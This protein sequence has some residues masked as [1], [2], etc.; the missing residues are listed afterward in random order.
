[1]AE[2]LEIA[3]RNEMDEQTSA[4]LDEL[5]TLL[6]DSE[7]LRSRQQ[8]VFC[9]AILLMLIVL[10]VFIAGMIDYF[11]SY[12]KEQVMREIIRQNRLFLG[13]PYHYGANRKNDQKLIRYFLAAMK[14]E[15]KSCRPILRQ[16]VRSG[17]SSLHDFSETELRTFFQNQLYIRLTAGTE[18]YT[19]DKNLR[20]DPRRILL[21][22]QLNAAIAAEITVR[23]FDRSLSRQENY[24]LFQQ[25]IE[26]LR[27]SPIYMELEQ[28]PLEMVEERML[29]NLLECLVCRL[30]E[31]KAFDRK[32][33]VDGRTSAR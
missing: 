21:L 28:E 4:R 33:N 25:E 16:T 23:L 11:R 22:R 14:R 20:L 17:I 9:G 8:L 30:N 2:F 19:A 27:R 24:R 26:T 31:N 15:M 18:Q 3:D 32:D 10:A 6:Q 12:P 29:E 13:N 7:K 1:M 5:E